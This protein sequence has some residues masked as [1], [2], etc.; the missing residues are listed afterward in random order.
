MAKY[1]GIPVIFANELNDHLC[2][3]EQCTDTGQHTVNR[4]RRYPS[5]DDELISETK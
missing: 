4:Y 3:N 2:H 1:E 5:N